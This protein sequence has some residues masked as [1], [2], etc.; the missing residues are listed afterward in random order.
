MFKKILPGKESIMEEKLKVLILEDVPLDAELIEQELRRDD[1][2]FIAHR[3][4]E[5][6]DYRRELEEFKPN[7]ILAD[8]SLP[9]FDGISALQIASENSSHT[10]FIFVSGKMGEDFAVEM[11]KRGATD[12]VLKHNLSKLGHAV[13][14]ALHEAEEHLEKKNTEK[15]LL[16]SEKKYRA[17]FELSPDYVL[18]LSTDGRILDLN[19]AAEQ[20]IGLPRDK[21]IGKHFKEIVVPF[22][23]QTINN[24]NLMDRLVNHNQHDI[25]QMEVKN[26]GMVRYTEIHHA[27]LLNEGEIQAV[28]IIARDITKRKKAEIELIQSKERLSHLNTYLEAIINASPFAIIDLDP[29]CTVKSLWNPAAENIYGWKKDEVLGKSLPFITENKKTEQDNLMSKVLLG[30]SISGVEIQRIRK[31]GNLIYTMMAA[32][33]LKDSDG[34]T[35]GIMSTSADISDMVKA[36]KQI[37]ASLEEKEVLIKEIHHRVKN[38]LQII[39]SLISLQASYTSEPEA[40][41][42]FQ[43]SKN[44]IRSMALIH[45]KLYQSDDLVQIDFKEYL[46]SLVNMLVQF[47][48]KKLTHIELTVNCDNIYLDIDTAISLGLIVNELLSNCF[49]HAFREGES[50]NVSIELHSV[51][52]EY[53]LVVAD[54]GIGFPENLDFHK[55]DSLGL[56]IVQT[57]TI[58][59]KGVL[60]LDR[61]TGTKINIIFPAS[62]EEE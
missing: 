29:D 11:L 62:V 39:S 48:K 57:L 60:E 36:E 21:L 22:I 56:Q 7:I 20:D 52:D 45:E 27:P 19:H 25:F 53:Q 13:K 35:M 49:K 8:H 14:R 4:D 47:F 28:Q 3:V 37:K 61:S 38:N 17:L 55:T 46:Q 30:E 15:A 16:E 2:N 40:Q 5:E 6:I 31:D 41:K 18:L 23:D 32:A 50:G 1:I 34:N 24:G 51:E 58:Q 44:R 43:E 12:Y 42:M 10:P 26:S 59:L 33:P 9:H 54:N